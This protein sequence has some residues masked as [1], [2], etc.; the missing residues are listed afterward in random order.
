MTERLNQKDLAVYFIAGTQNTDRPLEEVVFE[1]LRGG[2]SMFQFREKGAESIHGHQEKLE[3]ARKLKKICD[4]FHIPFI[5]NDDI[6]LALESNASGLHIGQEDIDPEDARIRL[7]ED[8]ILGVSAYTIEE[9]ET[10]AEF[11]DYLGVGPMYATSSKSDAKR[12][13]GPERIEQMRKFGIELP[14]VAIGGIRLEHVK[15][16]LHAGADGVSVISS[17]AQAELPESAAIDFAHAAK[18]S[19]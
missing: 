7:G 8:K 1:A 10:A 14:I 18:I 3:L 12:P 5:I 9:A 17:I 13:V 4:S 11:A 19:R 2:V 16:I 6:E 15:E